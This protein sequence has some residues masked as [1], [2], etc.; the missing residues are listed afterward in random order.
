MLPPPLNTVTLGICM[1]LNAQPPSDWR[2]EE[3]PYEIA[4]HCLATKSKILILL[5][6]WLDSGEEPTEE[7][8][9]STLNFWAA[10]LRPLW[11][12][13]DEG[14]EPPPSAGRNDECETNPVGDG[15]ETVVVVCNRSGQENG[16][17]EHPSSAS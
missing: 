16:C 9:W 13:S 4:D 7:Q 5:N 12:S 3:G 2:L 14:T 8:D 10:R 1:D 17:C 6:A 15:A 11:N